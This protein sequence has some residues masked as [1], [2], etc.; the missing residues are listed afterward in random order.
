M[1]CPICK[2]IEG[3]IL[4][5]YFEYHFDKNLNSVDGMFWRDLIIY[6]FECKAQRISY[7]YFSIFVRRDIERNYGESLTVYKRRRLFRIFY[8]W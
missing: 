1:R 4:D 8:G 5:H 3:D 6:A 7:D 2:T